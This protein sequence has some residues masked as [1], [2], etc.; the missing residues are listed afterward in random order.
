MGRRKSQQNRRKS[1]KSDETKNFKKNFGTA[2]IMKGGGSK[3]EKVKVPEERVIL[4]ERPA[5]K[6][7][8][9]A[10]DVNQEGNNKQES[11]DNQETDAKKKNLADENDKLDTEKIENA[12]DLLKEKEKLVESSELKSEGKEGEEDKED[13]EVVVKEEEDE[14]TKF[15]NARLNELKLALLKVQEEK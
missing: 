4:K 14:E 2:N 10:D 9:V 3:K 6:G 11:G 7:T 8:V 1:V 13:E 15:I 5:R 12:G